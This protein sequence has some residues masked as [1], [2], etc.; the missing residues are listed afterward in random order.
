MRKLLLVLTGVCIAYLLNAQ[1][2]VFNLP[3]QII[4]GNQGIGK[5]LTSD[6]SGLGSWQPANNWF[7]NGNNLNAT[8]SIGSTNNYAIN[9]ITNGIERINIGAN[10]TLRFSGVS[11]FDTL[12]VPD[13]YIKADGIRARVIHI[14]DSSIIIGS[15]VP[16]QLTNVFNNANNVTFNTIT[17]PDDQ[18]GLPGTL[19]PLLVF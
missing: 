13:G 3:V 4:D 17:M 11:I 15:Q 8:T 5:V 1:Q 14:G 9:L 7:L 16:N 12:L 2:N 18:P 10:D 6:A 19:P